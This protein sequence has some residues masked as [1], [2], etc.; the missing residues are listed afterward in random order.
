MIIMSLSEHS[1]ASHPTAARAVRGFTLVELMVSVTIALF[2]IGGALAIVARTKNTFAAQNQLAQLQDNERLAMN[3]MAEVIESA[4]Y[5]P[6]PKLYTA[7]G[8]LPAS[9]V[10]AS[11][12]QG[13]FGN[14]AAGSD[15]VYVRFGAGLGD[16]VYGC[17]GKSN[18]AT[19]PYDKFTN[20]FYVKTTG[21]GVGQLPQLVCDFT[22]AGGTTTVTLVNGVSKLQIFYGIK[23]GTTDTGSCA[24]N[25][26]T[27]AQIAASGASVNALWA[28][29]C[30]VKVIATFSNPMNAAA[31]I[32]IQ[33]VIA[34][35]TGAGVNS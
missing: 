24:D 32:Q 11:A 33:R 10:F 16:N 27:Q 28:S 23:A 19:A 25:Y 34:V 30:A 2:L 26:V 14:T 9:G 7:G 13:I 5:F 1:P 8:V 18:T 4:G 35:M 31:P 20:K 29:V 17:S 3:F 15:A 21:L 12:G 22:N 6:N